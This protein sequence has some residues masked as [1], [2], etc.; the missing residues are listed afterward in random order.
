MRE[1]IGE[2]QLSEQQHCIMQK[3][4][5]LDKL[6]KAMRQTHDE[7]SAN[8]K[9][10]CLKLSSASMQLKVMLHNVAESVDNIEVTMG[11]YNAKE[12]HKI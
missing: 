12:K 11:I 4:F 3:L 8:L 10:D 6:A 1:D 7:R 2:R 5:A 9:Q